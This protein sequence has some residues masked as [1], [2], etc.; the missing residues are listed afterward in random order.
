MVNS[1]KHVFQEI[2]LLC[3]QSARQLK[4]MLTEVEIPQ[5]TFR[6]QSSV[7][8]HMVNKGK[9]HRNKIWITLKII[10]ISSQI[11][12]CIPDFFS[13][14]SE[15]DNLII[16]LQSNLTLFPKLRLTNDHIETN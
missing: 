3:S 16:T 4:F 10:F 7:T 6:K 13:N 5:I 1:K 9:R 2:R 14:M 12:Q 11:T 8:I 15:R